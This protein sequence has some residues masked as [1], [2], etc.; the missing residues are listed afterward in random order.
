MMTY[1]V[2]SCEVMSSGYPIAEVLSEP[3]EQHE[4]ALEKKPHLEIEQLYVTGFQDVHLS[5]KMQAAA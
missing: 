3:C 2:L 4:W 5:M 1:I